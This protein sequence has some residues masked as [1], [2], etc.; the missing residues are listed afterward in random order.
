MATQSGPSGPVRGHHALG[1]RL[2]P[3]EDAAVDQEEVFQLL[4]DA[5]GGGGVVAPGTHVRIM[6][7]ARGAVDFGEEVS[8]TAENRCGYGD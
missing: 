8:V 4:L 2:E 1:H 7:V 3:G 5:P 6:R